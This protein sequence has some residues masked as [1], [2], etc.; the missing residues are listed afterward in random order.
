MKNRAGFT[1]VELLIAVILLSGKRLPFKG[2]ESGI[3]A[4]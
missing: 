4:G 2:A 1:I 3:L